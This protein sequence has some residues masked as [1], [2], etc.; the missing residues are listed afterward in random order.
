[1]EIKLNPMFSPIETLKT[2]LMGQITK[3]DDRDS[4]TT[5]PQVR[6][7]KSNL[8]VAAFLTGSNTCLL[9]EDSRAGRHIHAQV[10]GENREANLQRRSGVALIQELS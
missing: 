9:S 2:V 1:V 4:S 5:T 10:Q 3:V 7:V 8:K 6:R